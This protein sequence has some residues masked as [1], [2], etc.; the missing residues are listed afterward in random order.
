MI[1]CVG[2]NKLL[3]ESRDECVGTKCQR[4]VCSFTALKCLSVYE[5]LEIDSCCVAVLSC[6]IL[7]CDCSGVL[8]LLFLKLC[9]N[10][11]VCYFCLRLRNLKSF[12]VAKSYLWFGSYFCCKD[13]WFARLNLCY[14]DLRLGNDLKITLSKCFAVMLRNQSV[15][16]I[17]KEYTLAVHLLDHFSR[18]FSFTESR[19]GNSAFRFLICIL[20]CF[21]KILG[22]N[23]DCKFR[24]V[25]LHFFHL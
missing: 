13:K 22:G 1:T 17:L 10:F 14:I 15:S 8:L 20:H 23:L 16:S 4:I 11:L 2:T 12:I 9:L 25:F 6:T 18:S 19:N 5:A 24:H 7:N 21:V 3:L